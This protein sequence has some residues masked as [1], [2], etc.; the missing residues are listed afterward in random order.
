MP[1]DG[2]DDEH[3]GKP[4]PP[5]PQ[6]PQSESDSTDDTSSSTSTDTS[7]DSD[8]VRLTIRKTRKRRPEYLHPTK[9]KPK[10][11]RKRRQDLESRSIEPSVKLHTFTINDELYDTFR[12]GSVSKIS[13]TKNVFVNKKVLNDK[14]LLEDIQNQLNSMPNTVS[15][16]N[17]SRVSEGI[18]KAALGDDWEHCYDWTVLSS[19]KHKDWNNMTEE[20]SKIGH[21]HILTPNSTIDCHGDSSGIVVNVKSKEGQYTHFLHNGEG[22]ILDNSVLEWS[23]NSNLGTLPLWCLTVLDRSESQQDR[24]SCWINKLDPPSPPDDSYTLMSF[25]VK[26]EITK[27]TSRQDLVDNVFCMQVSSSLKMSSGNLLPELDELLK[28]R[29]GKFSHDKTGETNKVVLRAKLSLSSSTCASTLPYRPAADNE[30]EEVEP[31]VVSEFIN[32]HL[33]AIYQELKKVLLLRFAAFRQVSHHFD[34]VYDVTFFRQ[35]DALLADHCD[36]PYGDGPGSI[37][38][39]LHIGGAPGTVFFTHKENHFF[40][41]HTRVGTLYV[42][43][44]DPRFFWTHGILSHVGIS[45]GTQRAILVWRF[46]KTSKEMNEKWFDY[47]KDTYDDGILQA[48]PVDDELSAA[49]DVFKEAT[50]ARVCHSYPILYIYIYI[51]IRTY[52]I[53][54]I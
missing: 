44:G 27:S 46:G 50:I 21:M 41:L 9:N 28:L 31:V 43:K 20:L 37:I 29:G 11:K 51:L 38:A 12:V 7:D 33:D 47:W 53:V 4:Q 6:S 13:W 24:V 8:K 40:H 30:N 14:D 32:K 34:Y 3:D 1:D 42:F 26:G 39:V 16:K 17:L 2:D 5:Q 54:F 36:E 45:R 18:M 15:D 48:P 23:I 35:S 19:P 10:K 22:L 52:L 49:V 25:N